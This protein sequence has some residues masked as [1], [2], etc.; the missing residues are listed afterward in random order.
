MPMISMAKKTQ[1]IV[2]HSTIMSLGDILGS[3]AIITELLKLHN[4]WRQVSQIWKQESLVIL[5][6]RYF[7][8]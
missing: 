2:Q 5:N 6:K 3:S 8:G 1:L 7:K 4:I